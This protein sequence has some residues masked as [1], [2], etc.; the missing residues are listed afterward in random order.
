LAKYEKTEVT[1][2]D[3]QHEEM[4][5]IVNEIEEK[6]RDELEKIFAEGDTHGVGTQVREVWITDKRQQLDQF[7]ADQ[8]RNSESVFKQKHDI[9]QISFSVSGK[10]SNQWSMVTIRMGMLDLLN[11]F[12][13]SSTCHI[14]Q[15]PSSI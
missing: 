6:S 13:I 9:I 12:V 15:K 11:Y 14:L 1:L 3:D 7:R 4:S 10:R 5:A 8:Q 2:S